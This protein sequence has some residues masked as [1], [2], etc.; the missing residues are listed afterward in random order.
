MLNITVVL[1]FK[2]CG[3]RHARLVGWL[4]YALFLYNMS[5]MLK[6]KINNKNHD[7]VNPYLF[8]YLFFQKFQVNY[9]F[10]KKKY[11]T[12]VRTVS[13]I[14]L[15]LSFKLF[16]LVFQYITPSLFYLVLVLFYNY[17][18]GLTNLIEIY[19]YFEHLVS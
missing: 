14:L 4:D 11:N 13:K 5:M 3:K 17:Y 15:F 18:V 6:L 16:F 7:F 8:I 9:V 1:I 12:I 19:N 2:F 10:I